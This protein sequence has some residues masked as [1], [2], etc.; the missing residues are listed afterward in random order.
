MPAAP[1]II[2]AGGDPGSF[3]YLRSVDY[4]DAVLVAG[5]RGL[6][7]LV[8]LGSSPTKKTK[9]KLIK[10]LVGLRLGGSGV[11]GGVGP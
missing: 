9:T 2:F 11:G 5:D 3:S 10:N 7:V 4:S 6:A 1:T 8:E